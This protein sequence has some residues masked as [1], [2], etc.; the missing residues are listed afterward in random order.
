M[1]WPDGSFYDGEW[2]NNSINGYGEYRWK[3]GRGYIG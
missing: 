2:L 3:D 1:E